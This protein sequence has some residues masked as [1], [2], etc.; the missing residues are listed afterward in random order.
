MNAKGLRIVGVGLVTIRA[1]PLKQRGYVALEYA[2]E[3]L[4]ALSITTGVL[5][6]M[7]ADGVPLI[8]ENGRRKRGRYGVSVIETPRRGKKSS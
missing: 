4:G 7:L 2:G 3:P 8:E 6:K 5:A 1:K